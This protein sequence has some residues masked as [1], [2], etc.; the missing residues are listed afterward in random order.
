MSEPITYVLVHGGGHGGWCWQRTARVLRA[1]GHEVYTPTLTGFGER[2]HLG[3][4]TTPFET[5]LD[6]VTNL[7]EFE[8]LQRVVLVGHSM[9]GVII[10]RV[11]QLASSRI[12]RVIWLAAVVCQDGETLIDAIPQTPEIAAAVTINDDGT[13]TQDNAKLVAAVLNDGTAADRAWVLARHCIYPPAA[14]VEPGRL[15]EFLA[16]GLP[17]SYL[18]AARDVTITPALAEVFASRLPGVRRSQ[19]D[20]G[21]DC[22]ISRPVETAQALLAAVS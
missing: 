6:D 16:L 7:L 10:P 15:T 1:M 20:A 8:D 11:A 17:T 2:V 9:G 21:H 14:L 4:P 19:I 13:I 12:R 22:M 5:F 18:G 3:S